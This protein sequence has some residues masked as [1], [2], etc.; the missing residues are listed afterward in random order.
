MSLEMVRMAA[1]EG[2]TDIVASPH[3]SPEYRYQPDLVAERIAE[4]QAAVGDLIRIH[5][6]CD[7]HLSF[8]NITDA[9]AHP[10]KYSINGK[11]YLL[12]EFSDFGI[13]QNT[14]DLFGR[15]MG[16][17]MVP[18]ITH[19]ERNG[20]L[21]RRLPDLE[22]WCAMG[23]LVQ[24]TAASFLGRFGSTA[25]RFSETLMSHK[26]CHLVASDAHDPEHR[27]P[28]L[29]PARQW[30]A[31]RYGE[32]SAEMLTVLTP[33]AIIDGRPIE[34]VGRGSASRKWFEFWKG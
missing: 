8:D 20:L 23:C 19:P 17:G 5:R 24:V 32:E 29:K 11:G 27:P 9:L 16:S 15:L 30:L 22:K 13:A 28:T 25:Q 34:R 2:T 12:V 6:G 21:H 1:A 31:D 4:L 10:R 33:Q 3:S 26:L 18:V 7:F 14:A